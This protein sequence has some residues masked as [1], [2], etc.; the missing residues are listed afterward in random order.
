MK[1]TNT[2]LSGLKLSGFCMQV[3]LLYQAA[4]PLYEGIGVMA[5]DAASEEEK[6][7]LSEMADKLRL[8]C[9]FSEAVDEAGCFPDYAREMIHLGE[10]T[11]TLDTA[12]KGLSAHYEKEHRLAEGLRRALTYPA[13]MVC[14]LLV[15][16]FVLFVKVM[17]VF[18]DVYEQLGASIPAVS[19]AAI[20]IGGWVSGI[21][22]VV[23]AVLA[24]FVLFVKFSGDA[25][26]RP[27]FAE[28]LIRSFREKSSISRL[29]ALRRLCSTLSVTLRCGLS[30][31]EGFAMAASM[32]DHSEVSAQIEQA[33]QAVQKGETFYDAVKD[34]GLFGGFELQLIRVASRAGQLDSILEKI[35]VDYDEKA[36][37]TLDSMM[38]RIEPV[39]VTVLAV[40]VGLV[41]LSVM[42]PL[43]GILSAIG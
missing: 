27:A 30:T 31:D 14:M 39:I 21:A 43:A 37:D 24:A 22:L 28:S 6:K 1:Q 19:Q 13:M 18:T 40:A 3:S 29:T 33:R 34:A 2:A 4:V 35:A 23:I 38:T 36:S 9:S 8:G 20:N 15:I 7:F 16:L 10:Q 41:L 32:A 42:L 12:L 26:K 17:P 25:G 5:E 11:G